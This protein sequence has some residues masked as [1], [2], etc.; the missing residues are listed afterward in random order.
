MKAWTD[1]PIERLG[2][3]PGEFAPVRQCN[4]LSYDQDKYV[5]IEVEGLREE[6]KAGYCYMKPGRCGEVPPLNR[7]LLM[8]LPPTEY[9]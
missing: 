1:Y 7:R 3:K 2:D 6:I 9:K 5:W 8:S 4:V